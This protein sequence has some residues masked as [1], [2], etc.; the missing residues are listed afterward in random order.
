MDHNNTESLVDDVIHYIRSSKLNIWSDLT[1]SIKKASRANPYKI[2]SL[3]K[4]SHRRLGNERE[5]LKG[6]PPLDQ[7]DQYYLMWEEQCAINFPLLYAASIYLYHYATKRGCD[8]FLFATRDCCHWFKVFK[9]MFPTVNAHYFHCS[10]NM[11]EKAT[12]FGNDHFKSYVTTLLKPSEGSTPLVQLEKTIFVDIHGTAK[13]AFKYFERQFGAVPHC[14]LL[15]ATLKNYSLFPSITRRYY[16]KNKFVN[17]IFDARGSPIE[18]LNYD[19][20]GTLQ[21]YNDK[22]PVRDDME[23]SMS[24][25]EAYHT[26]ID[27]IVSQLGVIDK[28]LI[29][30]DYDLRQCLSL[31]KKMYR[32][33]LNNK[34]VISVYIMHPGRHEKKMGPEEKKIIKDK[35]QKRKERKKRREHRQKEGERLSAN[36]KREE[37][38]KRKLKVED[39]PLS[40][41]SQ[42]STVQSKPEAPPISRAFEGAPNSE[43][44]NEARKAEFGS[45]SF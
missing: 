37:K 20:V 41:N 24:R 1:D 36:K 33:I 38:E 42:A 32:V 35:K 4:S 43:T 26:C 22:G 8:T 31:I 18:M 11:F 13:R 15:S 2:T 23:Y 16:E 21:N 14:F 44:R 28:D 7:Y 29:S 40:Q 12:K 34:P 30:N 9:K 6:G 25:L 10:R 45:A 5:G 39:K 17:L 27:Y 3:S 19:I